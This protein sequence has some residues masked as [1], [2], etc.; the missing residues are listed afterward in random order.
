MQV[1]YEAY[2]GIHYKCYA[3]STDSGA[4]YARK[5]TFYRAHCFFIQFWCA[6][7][8]WVLSYQSS[9]DLQTRIG[10][11]LCHSWYLFMCILLRV[12]NPV[13]LFMR[14]RCTTSMHRLFLVSAECQ[15]DLWCVRAGCSTHTCQLFER[16]FSMMNVVVDTQHN[17]ANQCIIASAVY[18]L[19]VVWHTYIV[20]PTSTRVYARPCSCSVWNCYDIPDWLLCVAIHSGRRAIVWLMRWVYR[21][22]WCVLQRTGW[23]RTLYACSSRCE[24]R[25]WSLMNT[26]N[27]SVLALSECTFA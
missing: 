18:G 20:D 10:M 13:S 2:C 27:L 3:D 1:L 24:W 16:V 4:A 9:V 12:C 25:L 5:L 11:Y 22:V 21:I 15:Y 26:T 19:T 8:G 6:C 7:V 17:L 14:Q 23:F